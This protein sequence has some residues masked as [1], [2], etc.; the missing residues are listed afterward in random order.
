MGSS[1]G[2]SAQHIERGIAAV[3]ESAHV[4]PIGDVWV[5]P[6]DVTAA[7]RQYRKLSGE[8]KARLYPSETLDKVAIK[9]R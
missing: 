1:M 6:Q 5:E 3:I 4:T 8:R 9:T 2:Q 7:L